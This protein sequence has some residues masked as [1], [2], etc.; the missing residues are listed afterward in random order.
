MTSRAHQILTSIMTESQI[1]SCG[2]TRIVIVPELMANPYLNF[3]DVVIV[4]AFT[5]HPISYD[6][7]DFPPCKCSDELSQIS[8]QL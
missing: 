2:Y 4:A 6:H 1:Y 5:I 3:E 7:S 8:R